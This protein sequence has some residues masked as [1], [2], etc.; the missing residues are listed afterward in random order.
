M[1]L[2]V[3]SEKTFPESSVTS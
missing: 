2:P 1:H 3:A